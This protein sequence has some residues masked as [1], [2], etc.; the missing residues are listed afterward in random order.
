MTTS[1]KHFHSGMVGAPVLGGTAGALIA[2]LDACLVNGFGLVTA[3]SVVVAGGIATMT[4]PAGHS[5]AIGTVALVAGATPAGLNGEARILMVTA[6]TASYATTGISDQTATGTITAK[7]APPGWSKSFSGTNKA[8]YRADA[9]ASTRMFLRVDDTDQNNARVVGYGSMTDIDTG[10]APFPSSAQI[11]GGGYWPKASDASG[12]ARAWT[13]VVDGLTAYLHMHTSATSPGVSGSL[14]V[15]GDIASLR[16]GDAYGCVLQAH[17]SAAH[18]STITLPSSVEYSA[19]PPSAGAYIARSYTTLGGA[20]VGNHGVESYA[21]AS[22]VSGGAG[23]W[24]IGAYPN[25]PNNG[26]MLTR[27]TLFEG[28]SHLRG[29]LRGC[30]IAAQPCHAAFSHMDTLAGQGAYAGRTLLAVKCG[31]PAGVASASVVFMDI[32]GPWG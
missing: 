20:I 16:S 30:L 26:L 7:L 15:F 18:T 3:T 11:S 28:A 8:V 12:T 10:V 22:G 31:A 19:L 1:V 5:F 14:W 29:M 32:T 13:V 4:F 21:A 27:K 17:S 9:P 24:Q 23:A 25:G 6:N 2:V